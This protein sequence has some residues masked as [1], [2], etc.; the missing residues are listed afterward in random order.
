[1]LR[2]KHDEPLSSFASK[3]N[4]R[5]SSLVAFQEMLQDTREAWSHTS[6]KYVGK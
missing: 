2:L 6:V 5:R 3:F 4:L 1:V